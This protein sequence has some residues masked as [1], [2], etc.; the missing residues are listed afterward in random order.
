MLT[1]RGT[2][3]FAAIRDQEAEQLAALAPE[4]PTA[5]MQSALEVMSALARDI[6]LIAAT[7]HDT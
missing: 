2:S 6:G 7:K 3:A 4:I 1:A 5:A